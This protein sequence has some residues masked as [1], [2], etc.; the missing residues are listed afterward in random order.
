MVNR[1]SDT[2]NGECLAEDLLSG[3]L[4]GKLTPVLKAA[5]EVHLIGCDECRQKLADFMRILQPDISEQE[6]AAVNAAVVRWEQRDLR[7]IP[8]RQVRSW[9]RVYFA[10]A[11]L[12]A[13]LVMG[14]LVLVGVFSAQDRIQQVLAASPD[15]PF[16]AEMANQPY[17]PLKQ[18]RGPE[19]DREF[20][21]QAKEMSKQ[22]T[23]AY[24]IG[25]WRLL[26]K[27]YDSAIEQLQ[28][29]ANDPGVSS[30]VLNDLGV[31]YLLRDEPG[32]P[33]RA[34]QQFDLALQRD[35]KFLP[36]L[37]NLGLLYDS[38]NKLEDA[39]RVWQQ[40]LDLDSESGWAKEVRRNKEDS[41]K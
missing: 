3:Y 15:R 35:P 14:V 13:V 37:F 20:A 18:T 11:T 29:A 41:K 27:E 19:T 9:K 40:Y 31:A 7:A 1:Q 25:R 2:G 39:G 4:E 32:D 12:A 6:M 30:E 23:E 28:V 26:G 10:L 22:A 38:T 5:C 21:A 24:D 16:E 36:A 33:D 34:K 8:S 17:R